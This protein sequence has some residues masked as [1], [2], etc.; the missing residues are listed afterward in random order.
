M[1]SDTLFG[2]RR[3]LL[4]RLAQLKCVSLPA[5]RLIAEIATGWMT[6]EQLE[7][8]LNRKLPIVERFIDCV[9]IPAFQVL[10]KQVGNS[11]DLNGVLSALGIAGNLHD[12]VWL[13]AVNDGSSPAHQ[14]VC[15]A[16]HFTWPL[17]DAETIESPVIE[18]TSRLLLASTL[19]SV[20]RDGEAAL[21]VEG[22]LGIGADRRPHLPR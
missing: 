15:L 14:L 4:R 18:A 12:L 21:L 2:L 13:E 3:E 19:R 6:R 7:N 22:H 1:S 5:K 8:Y 9:D 11:K 20:G 10:C 16:H 17:G